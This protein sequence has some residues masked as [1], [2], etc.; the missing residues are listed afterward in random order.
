MCTQLCRAQSRCRSS[1]LLSGLRRSQFTVPPG[2]LGRFYSCRWIPAAILRRMRKSAGASHSQKLP[3]TAPGLLLRAAAPSLQHKR[4]DPEGEFRWELL[5][6]RHEDPFP[7]EEG[8][9]DRGWLVSR[10]VAAETRLP[11]LHFTHEG[12][13]P[14]N[15]C[16]LP[17][18]SSQHP[19]CSSISISSFNSR[20]PSAQPFRFALLHQVPV[21]CHV[22]ISLALC[23]V[24]PPPS[25][26]SQAI[27]EVERTHF[28]A[29]SVRENGLY[30][31][32]F[33]PLCLCMRSV[34]Q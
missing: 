25:L 6:T 30:H 11:Y 27:P 20:L 8:V 19:G 26:Q 24:P 14:R 29:F 4:R 32:T 7:W 23:H 31:S 22:G 15:F 3:D 28:S 34:S 33:T 16:L 5:S 2:M 21:I 9:G 12:R 10:S 13:L 17:L 1:C 18:S